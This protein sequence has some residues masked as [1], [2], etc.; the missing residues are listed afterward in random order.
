[1]QVYHRD[2][3]QL[4]QEEDV[5][6]GAIRFTYGTAFGRMLAKGL[7]CRKFVSDLYGAW[8]KSP[9]SRGKVRRFMTR[10]KIRVDDCTEQDFPNFNAFFTRQRKEYPR[11]CA[12]QELPAVA[13]SRLTVLPIGT[14][15]VFRI[16]G[17][18]YTTAE[19]L[20]DEALAAAYAGGWCMIFRLA[21]DDYHRYVYP[22]DG[23]QEASVHIPGVLHTVNPIA[24]ELAVYRRNTRCYTLL[25]TEHFGDVIEME[26]GALLVGRI[27]NHREDAAAF[28]KLQEKGYFQYGGS[29]VI[30]L[31]KQ[32]ILIP[33]ADL[34]K[35]S[36]Q[37]IESR[38]HLGER[39]GCAVT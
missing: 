20:N 5:G 17:V 29:T 11:L 34:L 16:K 22:D 32:G 26:V 21:P 9:L 8:Q 28:S 6:G 23:S 31:L 33:D 3:K 7:L 15:T 12:G 19:L 13:D 18:P 36:A 4:V 35:Y 37:G 14:D 39:V 2:T 1:M 10:Y 38:V 25:H 27:V 30:L 24:A